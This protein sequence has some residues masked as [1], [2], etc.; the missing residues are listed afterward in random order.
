MDYVGV[1]RL[2]WFEPQDTGIRNNL[3]KGIKTGYVIIFFVFF[4]FSNT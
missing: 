3:E 2:E 1:N 4:T